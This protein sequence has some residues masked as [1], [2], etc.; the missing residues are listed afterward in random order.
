[1][2]YCTHRSCVSHSLP[3]PSPLLSFSF[4]FS[5]AIPLLS[6][7][8]TFLSAPLLSDPILCCPLPSAA[9]RVASMLPAVLL[10]MLFYLDQN[11]SVRAVNACN[12]KKVR[13]TERVRERERG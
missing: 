9:Y 12:L 6:S 8:L 4:L 13:E 5:F 2:P 10:T 3:I 1:M 7:F 11:I